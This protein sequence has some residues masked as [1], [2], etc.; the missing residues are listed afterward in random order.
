LDRALDEVHAFQPEVLAVSAGF[1]AYRGDPITEMGLEIETFGEIG[2]RLA[3]LRLPTFAVLEGGYA[4]ALPECIEQ[5]VTP[6]APGAG[7]G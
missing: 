4:P 5:F 3:A 6:L 1:D 7:T 2:A